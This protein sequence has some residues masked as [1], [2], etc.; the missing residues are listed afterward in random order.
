MN[1]EI[2]N[3]SLKINNKTILDGITTTF[4]EGKIT[5]VLGPNGCGKTTLIKEIIKKYADTKEL[6]Y[7][8]QETTGYLNLMVRDV[9]E[10]SRY[11]NNKF[12]RGLSAEDKEA[13]EQAIEMMDI[14]D[15]QNQL[16]DTLS[17]GEKQRVMMARALAQE[18]D[19]L[20]L[21]EPTSNLDASHVRKINDA[22]RQAKSAIVVMHDI[23]EAARLGDKYILMNNG[24]IIEESNTL[25]E[26]L[27]DKTFEMDFS[28]MVTSDG[29]TIFY[30]AKQ[31]E[32][33][34][35]Q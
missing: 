35:A 3:L 19:W 28:K 20:I 22:V 29:Q 5:V 24:R 30:L 17:G 34:R 6:A 12:Y 8:A 14:E 18:T 15:K 26:D 2:S 13:I 16:F 7:V 31:Q 11:S 23:N 21:D 33:K 1:L 25:T 27:L 10:L 9:I 32:S 4:E